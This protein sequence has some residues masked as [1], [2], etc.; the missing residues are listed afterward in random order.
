M[1]CGF[2][3]AIMDINDPLYYVA[4]RVSFVKDERIEVS[5]RVGVKAVCQCDRL[6][7]VFIRC[8]AL[9]ALLHPSH[10]EVDY[11][12]RNHDRRTRLP[13]GASTA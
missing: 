7:K 4:F 9:V 3:G 5:V 12:L 1:V 2:A 11:H 10:L 13:P 6:A 8:E